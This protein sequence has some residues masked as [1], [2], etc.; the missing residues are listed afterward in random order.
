LAVA[1]RQFRFR[2]L[3]RQHGQLHHAK[4]TDLRNFKRS[5]VSEGLHPGIDGD[6]VTDDNF[7][8]LLWTWR[9][10][11][12]EYLDRAGPRRCS[13]R[14]SRTN[15]AFHVRYRR[16][17]VTDARRSIRADRRN[18]LTRKLSCH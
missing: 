4:L 7:A 8:T 9:P 5:A 13:T 6:I 11:V 16:T 18:R 14:P 3:N 2:S 17:G 15:G 10:V 1:P 12:A